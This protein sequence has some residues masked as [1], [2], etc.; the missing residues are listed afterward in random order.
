MEEFSVRLYDALPQP[1]RLVA[2]RRS[3]AWLPLFIPYALLSTLRLRRQVA[4]VHLGDG[5]LALF[6]PLFEWLGGAPVTVTVHGLDVMRSVPGYR[7]LVS[8]SL[9]RL[10]GRVIAVSGHTASE[11]ERVHGVS[12][13]V[14]SNGVDVARFR[15]IARSPDPA[16]TRLQLG[17]P[18]NGPLIVTVGRLVERKGVHWFIEAVL[19]R[20][21]EGVL[22]VVAGDG[23]ARAMVRAA[24]EDDRRVRLLGA[25]DVATVDSLLAAADLFVAPNI[26]VPD[27]PEGYGIAPAEAAAAGVPVLVS[28][29][30]GLCYMAADAGVP[31]VAPGD[32][33]AWAAAVGAALADPAL[34]RARRPPR[35]WDDV[36]AGYVRIFAAV[37]RAEERKPR[38]ST[39]GR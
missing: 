19:P 16:A 17:L 39:R 26:P 37:A 32:A 29:L 27:N 31:T 25:V 9:R 34:A 13:H 24:A 22:Y 28:N 8:S 12:P 3:Q 5:L 2:L 10:R 6:A 33:D 23:P 11:V 38:R 35:G 20:L 15:A 1:K 14:V 21:D 18:A 30:E 4:H 36:A 7:G